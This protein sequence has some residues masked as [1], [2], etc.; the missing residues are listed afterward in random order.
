MPELKKKVLCFHEFAFIFLF[1]MPEKTV[2]KL[3]HDNKFAFLLTHQENIYQAINFID[4]IFEG[5]VQNIFT[6]N[7]LSFTGRNASCGTQP[8][9]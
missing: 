6:T 1:H 2:I 9:C 4:A 7:T 8:P 5:E 3:H